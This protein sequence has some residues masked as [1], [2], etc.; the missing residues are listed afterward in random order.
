[1]TSYESLPGLP[2][3][4]SQR[5]K[6]E[7]YIDDKNQKVLWNGKCIRKVCHFELCKTRPIYNYPGC[8][9]GIYCKLHQKPFMN[10]VQDENRIYNTSLNLERQQCQFE[11][12][13]KHASFNY[14]HEKKRKFCGEH[15]Q[16]DM[17]NIAFTKCNHVGCIRKASY[18]YCE[19]KVGLYCSTHKL[20]NM[21]NVTTKKCSHVGCYKFPSFNY[22]NSKRAIYCSTHKEEDM[23][24]VVE[25][26]CKTHLCNTQVMNKYKGFCV[27]CFTNLYPNEPLSTNFKNKERSVVDYIKNNFN[28]YDWIYD[29]AI[30]GGT[31]KRRPDL[32]CDM[33]THILIIEIDE[34]AHSTYESL[35]ENKRI[36]QISK[37]LGYRPTIFIRFNPD[38]YRKD[39]ILMNSCWS[40][41]KKTGICMVLKKNEHKWK[42]RLETLKEEIENWIGKDNI[43]QKMITIKYLFFDS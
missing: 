5:E 33:K 23:I 25:K 32:M 8:S 31:S 12:C 18:N 29:K 13:M 37:D 22:E 11:N 34:N 14:K 27:Y 41:C 26:T 28:Q 38:S 3:E 21:I 30:V 39:G 43:P 7:L 17:I 10:N 42:R 24:N 4:I 2:R 20:V 15:K 6:N 9:Q 16:P 1:M 40:I 19:E 36:M 35:C